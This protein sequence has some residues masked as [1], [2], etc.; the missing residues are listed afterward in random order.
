MN[1]TQTRSILEQLAQGELT[2]AE[3]EERLRALDGHQVEEEEEEHN[4]PTV[5]LRE[6]AGIPKVHAHVHGPS[7]L[8]ILGV[9][10]I[11]E[12]HAYGPSELTTSNE[13]DVIEVNC[14]LGDDSVLM[15][16]ADVDL[17]AE[18]NG[19]EAAIRNLRGTLQAEV[20]AGTFRCEAAL[21]RGESAI[22]ANVGDLDLVLDPTSDVHITVKAIAGLDVSPRLRKV[23]RGEWEFGNGTSTLEITGNSGS[24]SISVA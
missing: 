3:A 1:E 12:I 10:D 18:L 7:M 16:P 20:N 6:Y 15:I 13:G 11:E 2:P 8:E 23:G 22:K 5:V 14:R 24:I 21:T 4:E 9:D 19:A 17:T